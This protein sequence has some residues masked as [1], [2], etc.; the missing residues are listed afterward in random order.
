[1]A[2]AAHLLHPSYLAAARAVVRAAE[3]LPT[4]ALMGASC[5]Q[6][7]GFFCRVTCFWNSHTKLGA[8]GSRVGR[9]LTHT[10][11]TLTCIQLA[12]SHSSIVFW[13]LPHACV[14]IS[15]ES[16]SGAYEASVG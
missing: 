7:G 4:V 13:S 9:A 1:M 2:A 3:I 15:L 11:L 5:K 6:V 12:G 10:V 14:L 8:T 16:L